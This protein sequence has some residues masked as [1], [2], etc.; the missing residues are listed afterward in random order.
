MQL[1]NLGARTMLADQG[2]DD[3]LVVRGNGLADD[4][5]INPALLTCGNHGTLVS[6][7]DYRMAGMLKNQPASLKQTHV[8]TGAQNYCHR[9]QP[10]LAIGGCTILPLKASLAKR[11]NA[12]CHLKGQP[13]LSRRFYG[14]GAILPDLSS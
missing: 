5:D 1:E 6:C 12:P 7:C 9:F 10:F 3:S 14:E 4:R 13:G 11:N 2:A 8:R